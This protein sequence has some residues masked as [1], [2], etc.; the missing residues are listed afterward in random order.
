MYSLGS[1]SSTKLDN[2]KQFF[3]VGYRDADAAA[4]LVS[5]VAQTLGWNEIALIGT[6]SNDFGLGGIA[7]INR[8][9]AASGDAI[10]IVYYESLDVGAAQEDVEAA[11]LRA[12]AAKP[13]GGYVISAP[14]PDTRS[15]L[16]AAGAMNVTAPPHGRPLWLATEKVEF[17]DIDSNGRKGAENYICYA[18]SNSGGGGPMAA[19]FRSSFVLSY[20][21]EPDP[22][23]FSAYAQ[24]ELVAKALENSTATHDL[25]ANLRGIDVWT[26]AGRIVYGLSANTPPSWELGV[27][28]YR[29]ASYGTFFP[30]GSVAVDAELGRRRA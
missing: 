5:N 27:Y 7:G 6:E 25:V 4:I 11:V 19:E 14:G 1:S 28:Q 12:A 17:S 22:W 18:P 13:D 26:A 15:I 29:G 24:V 3:R 30:I 23:A 20:G 9:V 8:S 10:S 16:R 2:Y 21:H